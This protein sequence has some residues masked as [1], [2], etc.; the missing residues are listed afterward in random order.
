MKETTI[1][2]WF[3]TLNVPPKSGDVFDAT[4]DTIFT[5]LGDVYPSPS[6]PTGSVAVGSPLSG[7]YTIP[8]GT[9][10]TL[11]DAFNAFSTRGISASVNFN[12]TS[13]H[14]EQA[15]ATPG[16]LLLNASSTCASYTSPTKTLT[17]QK[18]GGGANPLVYAPLGGLAY[19]NNTLI[20]KALE[21]VS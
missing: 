13:G 14:I 15:P 3:M 12:V 20:G 11:A 16:G 7:N 9:F 21:M 8:G 10:A 1:S 4:C 19:P 5:T 17:I 6:S 18:N 2:G